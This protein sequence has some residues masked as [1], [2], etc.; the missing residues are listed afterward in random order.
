MASILISDDVPSYISSRSANSLISY[1]RPT[2]IQAVTL[3][4]LNKILDELLLLILSSAKSLATDRIKSDGILKVLGGQSGNGSGAG[5]VLAKN[6]VLEA[7]LELRSY[8]EG[9]RKEGGKMPLGLSATSRWD[10]TD[11]F[12]VHRA[13]EALRIR[14]QY[15][16]TLGDLEDPSSRTPQDQNIM[17]ADGRPVATITPGVSIYVTALLEFV[18]EHILQNVGKVIERDNSDEAGLSD[19]KKAMEEDE[20]TAFWYNKMSTKKEISNKEREE[21]LRGGKGKLV[22][23]PWKVP[24]ASE[25][26]EAAGRKTFQRQSASYVGKIPLTP[27]KTSQAASP[28]S[29]FSEAQSTRTPMSSTSQDSSSNRAA[30]SMATSLSHSNQMDATNSVTTNSGFD[31]P[32]AL[33]RKASTDKGWFGKRQSSYRASQET[34]PL[35]VAPLMQSAGNLSSSGSKGSNEVD[36]SED[37]DSLIVSGGTMKVSLTPNRLRAIE[38]TEDKEVESDFDN[39]PSARRRPGTMSSLSYREGDV[40]S[41]LMTPRNGGQLSPAMTMNSRKSLQ[42]DS[43]GFSSTNGMTGMHGEGGVIAEDDEVATTYPTRPTSRQSSVG[44]SRSAKPY[45]KNAAPPSAYRALDMAR[46]PSETTHRDEDDGV[47]GESSSMSSHRMTRKVL[48]SGMAGGGGSSDTKLQARNEMKRGSSVQD[49]VDIFNSTPPTGDSNGF[50]PSDHNGRESRMSVQSNDTTSN[51][52]G[53]KSGII[54]A[55][56]KMRNLFGRRTPSSSSINSVGLQSRN[57]TA[58]SALKYQNT[59]AVRRDVGKASEASGLPSDKPELFSR[60]NA[61]LAI[62]GATSDGTVLDA[63]TMGLLEGQRRSL[64]QDPISTT[65]E[66]TPVASDVEKGALSRTPLGE[67]VSKVDESYFP[68]ES[69][70]GVPMALSASK[71]RSPIDRKTT[72]T[73]DHSTSVVIRD[74]NSTPAGAPGSLYQEPR[75]NGSNSELSSSHNHMNSRNEPP[76]RKMPWSYNRQSS[77]ARRLSGTSGPM[78]PTRV[79]SGGSSSFSHGSA[80]G[81]IAAMVAITTNAATAAPPS[82]WSHGQS[83]ES[84]GDITSSNGIS[85]AR[86]TTPLSSTTPRSPLLSSKLSDT[87]KALSQLHLRMKEASSVEEC[88]FIVTQALAAAAAAF[89]H[90]SHDTEAEPYN[91]I[92]RPNSASSDRS[93]QHTHRGSDVAPNDAVAANEEGITGHNKGVQ[94][95]PSHAA[96]EVAP[97]QSPL[98]STL[99]SPAGDD[100][101]RATNQDMRILKHRNL[102]LPMAIGCNVND[103]QEAPSFKQQGD[104]AAWLL[105]GQEYNTDSDERDSTTSDVNQRSSSQSHSPDEQE[106]YVSVDESTFGRTGSTSTL[107]TKSNEYLRDTSRRKSQADSLRSLYRDAIDGREG[108][109]ELNETV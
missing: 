50:F 65:Q 22:G 41:P 63:L 33:A 16:S 51:S 95:Y 31:Q 48:S 13:Y 81:D 53:R 68:G 87:T 28:L 103:D 52:I 5:A 59:G 61:G 108:F 34:S 15:Y 55:G 27:T 109:D 75:A 100:V 96:Q 38:V 3:Y 25:Y 8:L 60:G 40:V 73:E 20:S 89:H 90:D 64:K 79:S 76:S 14:C 37:F 105:D 49:M 88:R 21:H 36:G 45:P 67:D 24:N 82:A 104:L 98:P 35:L 4:Y 32:P 74:N 44:G 18:A 11:T 7:E 102:M 106:T 62:E 47:D 107:L 9:Q 10:G 46:T 19:L 86:S 54:S 101:D 93:R 26:N 42:A 71:S 78:G 17:S 70:Y 85:G 39:K 83:R 97:L 6:A 69:K 12:P 30:S 94:V 43:N 99:P 72:S 57:A 56:G 1:A 84:N 2:R 66:K 92:N 58:D 91:G 80:S 23:K 77:A 29:G